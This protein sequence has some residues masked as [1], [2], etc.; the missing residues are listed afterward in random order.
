MKLPSHKTR[1]TIGA[2]LLLIFGMAFW[3]RTAPPPRIQLAFLYATNH[4][5]AGRIGVFGVVNRLNEKVT[6]GAGHFHPAKRKGLEPVIGDWGALPIG[7]TASFPPESTNTIE[8]RTPTNGGP[9]QLVL[10]CLPASK[11][12]LKYYSS[13]RA[14]IASFFSTWVP[15]GFVTSGRWYGSMFIESQSFEVKP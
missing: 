10:Y 12:T 5:Q 4:P 15:Q 9:Y 14:R 11:Q 3:L 13:P 8:V 2:A 1:L 7:G 6:C